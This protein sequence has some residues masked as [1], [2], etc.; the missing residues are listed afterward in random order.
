[1][2]GLVLWK[3]LPLS[4]CIHHR[5]GCIADSPAERRHQT[6][7]GSS[8]RSEA[9]PGIGQTKVGGWCVAGHSHHIGRRTREE[10][11]AATLVTRPQAS[12]PEKLA[13]D[14]RWHRWSKR[15]SSQLKKPPRCRRPQ[16]VGRCNN[17]SWWLGARISPVCAA[18]VIRSQ[19]PPRPFDSGWNPTVLLQ[20]DHSS[21]MRGH[22]WYRR[23]LLLSRKTLDL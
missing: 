4:P 19:G 5:G 23:S 21:C 9:G 12:L 7:Q 6:Y 20:S 10:R 16:S 8:R 3:A 14:Q 2:S 22:G 13:G 15:R 17:G 1:M 18:N 11:R